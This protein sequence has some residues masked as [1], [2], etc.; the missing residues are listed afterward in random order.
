[1]NMDK[2][3]VL[4]TRYGEMLDLIDCLSIYNG[5]AEPK[6]QAVALSYDEAIALR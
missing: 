4:L 5:A 3:D 2:H 1:M 6:R